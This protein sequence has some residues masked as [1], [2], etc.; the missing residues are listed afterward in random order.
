MTHTYSKARSGLAACL[1]ATAR[2]IHAHWQHDRAERHNRH[3]IA[4]ELGTCSDRELSELGFSRTDL[5]A[6]ACGTYQR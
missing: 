3:R 2:R 6:I 1:T 5:S 4:R